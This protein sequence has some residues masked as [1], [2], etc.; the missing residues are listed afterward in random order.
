MRNFPKTK[1]LPAMFIGH[2]SPMSALEDDAFTRTWEEIGQSLTDVRAILCISA[3]WET[4]GTRITA[5]ESPRTI[6]D[7]YGF[8]QALYEIEY[9]APGSP[10][11]AEAVRK[12]VS[13]END[14]RP[15]TLDDDWG[16]DHGSW[17]VLIKM[18]PN[19][20]IPVVQLSI[21]TRMS[22]TEHYRLGQ[23]LA[24]LREHGVL[25]IGSGN[26]VHNLRQMT[27]GDDGHDWAV[28][29]DRA[30]ADRLIENDH[31]SII[32]YQ[33]FGEAAQL[34]VPSDEHFVPLLYAAGARHAEDRLTFKNEAVT[35][36]A[37]SM[38]S[39]IYSS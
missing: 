38:R 11:L 1:R 3:H 7:F 15:V 31:Q 36:G 12:L 24:P 23:Q 35:M 26:I 2:G 4:E 17:S 21:D 5:M 30:I 18:F 19:A 29:F 34:S 27:R 20:R 32:N 14:D 16:L 9:P 8:P 6:H 22:L 25:I 10:A 28:E 39:V 33:Q 37:I 13:L